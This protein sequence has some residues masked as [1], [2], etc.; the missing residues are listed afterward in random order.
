M[1]CTE[2]DITAEVIESSHF[3]VTFR[4]KNGKSCMCVLSKTSSDG[5]SRHIEIGLIRRELRERLNLEVSRKCFTLQY[6]SNIY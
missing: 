1:L 2:F 6:Q 4:N 5:K 3:K